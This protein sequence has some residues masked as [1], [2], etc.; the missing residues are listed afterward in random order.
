MLTRQSKIL[1]VGHDDIIERSFLN[2]FRSKKFEN[3]YS[4]SEMALDTTL[5]SA[6]HDFFSQT[7]PE[8]VFL[9]STRSGG[10][11][12]NQKYAAE[13]IYHNLESQN[14]VI[15]SSYKFGVK[16]LIFFA[17]SCAYPKESPQPIKEEY[18]GTGPLEKTS[19]PY[20]IAKMAGIHLCQ[21]YRAHYGVDALV[22]VPATV[23][24]PGSDADL[25]KAHVLGALI[26]K[27]YKAVQDNQP[28]VV[29]WG[30]GRA[31]REFLYVEDFIDGCLFLAE[32][33]RDEGI[34]NL[35]CGYDVSIQE[36]AEMIQKISGYQGKIIFDAAK[37]DG[38]RQKLMDH[39]K[40]AQL[41][42]KARVGLEEGITKTYQWY[43]ETKR[44][45]LM[46]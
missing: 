6:V 44:T 19:E 39:S 15:H 41:G 29:V 31:R 1:L 27:F 18:L 45:E 3:V 16:K 32:R 40:L 17:G 20:A 30:T 38:T 46:K 5:Q 36:L 37:P 13:F 43:Q 33:Y 34:V 9:A 24:G 25:E 42:W 4:V 22:L 26:G 10:I 21:T 2:Y 14:N 28:E 11:E 7:R 12:A 35:G 8:Y 23:Y